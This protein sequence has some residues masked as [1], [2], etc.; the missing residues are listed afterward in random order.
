MFAPKMKIVKQVIAE[1]EGFRRGK[2]L[3]INLWRPRISMMK[4]LPEK[5]WRDIT[6]TNVGGIVGTHSTLGEQVDDMAKMG[7]TK[8]KLIG[9]VEQME[10]SCKYSKWKE[11]FYRY[12]YN[13]DLSNM[14]KYHDKCSKHEQDTIEDMSENAEGYRVHIQKTCVN[15]KEEDHYGSATG[16][17]GLL[18]I[19][20]EFKR[21][22]ELR[23][24][25][26]KWGEKGFRMK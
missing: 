20:E 7:M 16:E 14:K 26:L 6:L 10:T 11:K 18:N 13:K 25:F 22:Y 3:F 19:A 5:M 2:E 12:S 24:D 1:E 9:L 8:D 4:E 23:K 21:F 15:E 17:G